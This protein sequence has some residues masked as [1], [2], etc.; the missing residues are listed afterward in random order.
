MGAGTAAAQGLV[1]AYRV[2]ST[3]TRVEA[4]GTAGAAGEV[5][6]LVLGLDADVV[7]FFHTGSCLLGGEDLEVVRRAS[8]GAVWI[9]HEGDPFQRW[10]EPY[11]RRA[12]PSVRRCDAAFVFC[13]GYLPD[14]ARRAGCGLVT[15]T[16]SWVNMDRFAR[17]WSAARATEHDV[18]FVG[19]NIR[20][21][22]RPFPGARA[23]SL[24]ISRLQKRYGSRLAVYGRGWHGVGVMGP[25]GFDDVGEAYGRAR[26]CVGI[27][28]AVGPYQ[29]SNRLPIALATGIPLAHS[30]FTGSSEVLAGVAS[31]QFFEDLRGAVSVIDRM[32][33]MDGRSLDELSAS[34]RAVAATLSCDRVMAYMLTSARALLDGGDPLHVRNPWL[35]HAEQRL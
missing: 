15:Y 18:A 33:Q 24:L 14:V 4:V 21:W 20:S 30:A 23:R 32:L 31:W 16:P 11:K 28:H 34:Q 6:D 3:P 26:V 10:S 27:D 19:N 35:A 29:F 12:L 7:V 22:R 5:A 2:Y 9:Y 13:G 1:D 17:I 25:V 8:P